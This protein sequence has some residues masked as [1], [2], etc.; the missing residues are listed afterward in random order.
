M[1]NPDEILDIKWT[2]RNKKYY[3]QKGYQYTKI[4]DH[5]K[6]KAI[7]L[8]LNSSEHITATCDCVD[9]NN[10]QKTPYR[11]YNKI[12]KENG[13]YKCKPCTF[14]YAMKER[15]KKSHQRLYQTF[16]KKC[17]EHNCIPITTFDEFGGSGS[18][19][20]YIC[21]IHGQTRTYVNNMINTDAWCYLCGKDSMKQK[22]RHTSE[23]VKQMI[24]SKNGNIL[25]NTNEYINA[26]EKNLMVIC[27]SCGQMF[28]TSYESIQ[29]GDGRCFNCGCMVGGETVQITKED[30]I[31]MATINGI[32]MIQN[33]NDYKSMDT[34]L[35]FFC[36]SCN[37]LFLTT[38]HNYIKRGFT[39]CSDC[40]RS[41]NSKGNKMIAHILNCY[42]VDYVREFKFDD[43]KDKRKLP[44]D[45][46][47]P[48]YNSII[49]FDGKQHFEPIKYFGGETGFKTCQYHDKIKNDY[50]YNNGIRLLRIP[51]WEYTNLEQIII[52]F[53]GINKQ[54]EDIV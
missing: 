35:L 25:L 14:S 26:R 33:P 23:E 13:I 49:E 43:C 20:E 12:V 8:P 27:G 11:N 53:L 41:N 1:Y 21:P 19:V 3:E 38:P 10:S 22:L 29:N 42:N 45:F 37:N 47:L 48:K 16:L 46:Y 30:L 17:D 5:L 51:Y 9:C 15:D 28:I 24:E 40:A 2:T 44:F 4:G 34:K 50:C 52:Q 31:S 54:I 18:F 6:I 39:R 32:L 36:S 7:D